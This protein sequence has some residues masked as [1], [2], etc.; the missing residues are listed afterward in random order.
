MNFILV[1]L[2]H[3]TVV[4]FLP[5]VFAGTGMIDWYSFYRNHVTA[6]QN[7]FRFPCVSLLKAVD[8]VE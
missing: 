2:T 4:L 3:E 5:D 6:A 1:V 7:V 8:F